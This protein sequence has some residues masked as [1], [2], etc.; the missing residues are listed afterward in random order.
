M[1]QERIGRIGSCFLYAILVVFVAAGESG[2]AMYLSDRLHNSCVLAV[3]FVA[4]GNDRGF[5]AGPQISPK[6]LSNA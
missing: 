3:P 4:N 2:C 1:A 6:S 5:V